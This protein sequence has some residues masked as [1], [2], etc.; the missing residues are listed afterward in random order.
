MSEQTNTSY[1]FSADE[2]PFMDVNEIKAIISCLKTFRG[3]VDVLEWGSGN[4]TLYFSSFLEPGSEWQALEHNREWANKVQQR[5][6]TQHRDDVYLHH[7]ANNTSFNDGVDDGDFASFYDYVLYPLGLGKQFDLI[8]VDGRARVDC[9]RLGWKM[10]KANGV[11]VLHD[12]QRQEYQCGVPESCSFVKISNPTIQNEGNI[13]VYFMSKQPGKMKDLVNIL[14][15]VLPEYIVIEKHFEETQLLVPQGVIADEINVSLQNETVNQGMIDNAY[16]EKT[17]LFVNTYYPA[18]VNN[19]YASH[20][21]LSDSSYDEQLQSI[22]SEFFG[23]SDFYSRALQDAGW[24]SLDV[25][26]NCDP[27]QYAWS[28]E[29]GFCG[30]GL[31]TLVEQ[32]KRMRPEVVYL[33]DL[34]LATSEFL[35][36]IKAYTRLVVGQIASP[37]PPNVDISK[38]DIIVSSFPHFVDKFRSAGIVS[39][40]QPLSFEPR[41]LDVLEKKDS[42]YP[43]TFVGGISPAHGSGLDLLEYLTDVTPIE[44]WGY[45]AET[46]AADSRIRQRHHGEVWGHD[47]FNILH[48]SLITVN[49][50]IDVAENNANNMRLF[51]ATGCGALLITDYKDNLHELFEVGK[52]IVAYRSHEECAAL[53]KYYLEHPDKARKIAAAGQHRTLTEH[54]Y[55]S[56]LKYTAEILQRHSRYSNQHNQLP[57]A[58]YEHVSYNMVAITEDDARAADWDAW[59]SEVIPAKQRALVQDE[60]ES[61]YKGDVPVVYSVLT[62]ALRPMIHHSSNILE[63]GCA[64]GYYYEVLSYLLSRK[65]DYTGV[66]YSPALIDMAHSYYPDEEFIVAD[67]AHLPFDN[68]SYYF[69]ISSCVLLH[70]QNYRQHI[71]ESVRVAG[72]YIIAHRTP[73]CRNSNTR[74]MKKKAYGVDTV[75]LTFNEYEFLN[76][77]VSAGVKIIG[78]YEYSSDE[79]QDKYEVTYVFEK[80]S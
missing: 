27:L 76:T 6:N 58:D 12:A 57:S 14:T 13:A 71:Y 73:V 51:E 4:S 46:L 15:G 74:Y 2:I 78:A 80:T 32:I 75:E 9:M 30:N 33:Q 62:E 41:V 7:V 20:T 43:V 37:V 40:Y 54:T 24:S 23:D 68:D 31:G 1:Q 65:L 25:I 39:Y 36:S 48:N 77:F 22:Q 79:Q 38:L 21:G 10:L 18:F 63:I 44:F 16:A 70:V 28:K 45:G 53:I 19:H 5:I 8:L 67:G 47:M 56:R 29:N 61:M 55:A 42:L 52:E 35:A 69:V 50:H 64:S 11:M 66:D 26:A 60:L 59:K 49:R 3:P 72:K 34:S 17:C